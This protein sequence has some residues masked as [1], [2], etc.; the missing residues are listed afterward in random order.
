M[1]TIVKTLDGEVRGTASEGVYRF[2]GIPFAAPPVGAR[3]LRPPPPVE[4]WI[5]AR[6]DDVVQAA[7]S[8]S[9]LPLD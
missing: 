7:R 5:G 2:L 4:S 9:A 8:G 3:R 1:D 6:I